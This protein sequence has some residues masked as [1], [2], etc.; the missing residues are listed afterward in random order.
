MK[1]TIF[2]LGLLLDRDYQSVVQVVPLLVKKL[3]LFRNALGACKVK[4]RGLVLEC[5]LLKM[6]TCRL[7][8]V[9]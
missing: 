5:N 1:G 3:D 6:Y 8:C 4:V 7:V 9:S 2:S